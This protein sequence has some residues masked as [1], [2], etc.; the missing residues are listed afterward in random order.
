MAPSGA[1]VGGELSSQVD[2]E[3]GQWEDYTCQGSF[4]E[5]VRSVEVVLREWRACGT[6]VRAGLCL[7]KITSLGPRAAAI[8]RDTQSAYAALFA[9]CALFSTAQKFNLAKQ[10]QPAGSNFAPPCVAR[11][12]TNRHSAS[13]LSVV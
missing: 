8:A 3:E 6:G 13:G 12:E 7:I 2:D 4:E 10:P 5:L 9:L 1:A 11:T